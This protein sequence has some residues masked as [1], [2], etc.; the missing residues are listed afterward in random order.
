MLYLGLDVHGKWTTMVGF[1]PKTGETVRLERVGNE[2]EALAEALR[3]LP[4]PLYGVVEAGTNS[5]AMYRMLEPLF[6]RLVVAHPADLW[7]RRRDRR[8]KTDRR[9]AMR[10]AE[11]LYRGEITPV[12]V[13]DVR[14][15]DLRVLVR[16]KVR[17]S[18]WVT[19]LVNEIGSLLRS[20]GYVGQRSLLTK[21]GLRDLDEAELPG[22]SG[23]VLALWR[24]M[25]EL[26][27]Q[28]EGEL[29]HAVAAEAAVEPDCAVVDSVPSVG[30]F[31][32][33]LV[34]AEVGDINRFPSG[35][36]LV[37]YQGLA[38]RVMQSADHCR[39]GK[40]GPW[41]NR[42]LRYGMVL[43]A[44]RIANSRGDHSLRR[45]YVRVSMR[46]DRNSAKIEVARKATQIIYHL[47]K[48][49]EPWQD[50]IV[51]EEERATAAA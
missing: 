46:R 27:Q 3:G 47:L 12:W 45:L 21:R 7:D 23:R 14:T 16:G 31:T 44:N 9:D 41:G 25:L 26:A 49:R 10:M 17:A 6:E 37:S 40:L 29:D 43:L 34:R 15:Q 13:P 30:A 32:A 42:W 38:P 8:A 19:K 4:G 18:R 24:Q 35:E 5:W 20:W 33:L 36:A 1:D 48:H 11:M 50:E 51:R 28:I 39:Y 2:P 22:H